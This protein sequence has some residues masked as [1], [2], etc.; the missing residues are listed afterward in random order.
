MAESLDILRKI[1]HIELKTRQ[2]VETAFAGQYHS[3]FKGRGMNFEEVRQYAP[4]DEIRAIDWNVTARSGEAYVKKFTEE[5]DLTVMLMVDISASGLFGSVELSKRELAAEVAALLAFSAIRNSDKVGLLLFTGEVELF[6]PPRKG[7]AHTLR[8]IREVLFFEPKGTQTDLGQA[9]DYMNRVLRRR[10]I[11][12]LISDFQTENYE[13]ALGIT[14]QRHDMVALPVLDP[15]EFELPDAGVLLVE[16]SET[17]ELLE[18]NTRDAS[19]R[20]HL[21]AA[22]LESFDT[23]SRTLRKM[24]IDVVPLRTNTDYLPVLRAFFDQRE[25]R[26]GRE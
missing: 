2:L 3:V 18:L 25:R 20:N 21:A 22:A 7:R 17:G 11:C 4:G 23:T 14:A 26:R 16:D 24:G 1:R 13:R 19:V 8:I 12:F 15:A 10:C 5:R 9:L 6:I